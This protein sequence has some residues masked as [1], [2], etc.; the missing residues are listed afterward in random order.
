MGAEGR[1][2]RIPKGF[3]CGTPSERF[4]VGPGGRGRFR[5]LGCLPS[6]SRAG[7]YRGVWP[8]LPRWSACV[9][10]EP[11]AVLKTENVTKCA[12]SFA[13]KCFPTWRQKGATRLPGTPPRPVF[14]F[15]WPGVAHGA[16]PSTA[17]QETTDPF[18]TPAGRK[19]GPADTWRSAPARA[20]GLPTSPG[21]FDYCV[22]RWPRTL[23]NATAPRNA[24]LWLCRLSACLLLLALLWGLVNRVV[25]RR[26]TGLS[27]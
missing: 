19:E 26:V 22:G 23:G 17:R 10:G 16:P 24:S 15:V 9:A 4:G 20:E 18:D 21:A 5:G 11:R 7:A 1:T 27:R 6:A 8:F 2:P 14:H 25:L 3:L 12:G 13:A